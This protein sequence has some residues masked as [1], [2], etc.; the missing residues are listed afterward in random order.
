MARRRDRHVVMEAV[1]TMMFGAFAFLYLYVY[2]NGLLAHVQ[3]YL[4][5]GLTS[6]NRLVGAVIITVVLL[7]TSWLTGRLVRRSFYFLPA[8][9]H[10]PSCVLLGVLTDV[11]LFRSTMIPEFGQSWMVGVALVVG[12][13]FLAIL[14]KDSVVCYKGPLQMVLVNVSTLFVCLLL[15]VAMGNTSAEDHERLDMAYCSVTASSALVQSVSSEN[16]VRKS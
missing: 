4:S 6:Y 15:V 10:L 16:R 3:D 7:G 13:A 2:Q 8:V 9:Y 1:C 11:H 5:E 12:L 14:L